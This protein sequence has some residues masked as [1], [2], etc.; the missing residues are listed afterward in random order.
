MKLTLC[1]REYHYCNGDCRFAFSI[2][3][4][5]HGVHAPSVQQNYNFHKNSVVLMSVNVEESSQRPL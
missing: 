2:E 1:F 3:K 4:L 5:W